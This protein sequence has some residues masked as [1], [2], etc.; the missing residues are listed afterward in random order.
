MNNIS[1]GFTSD[2]FPQGTH[3]C[4]IYKDEEERKEVIAK[5]VESGLLGGELVGYFVDAISPAEMRDHLSSLGISLS[6]GAK[7]EQL[8][9]SDAVKTYCCDGCFEPA[10]MLEKVGEFYR[11]SQTEGY[12]GARA[13]GEMAWALRGIPGS[14]KLI[15]YESRLNLLVEQN[16]ITLICQYDA[17]RFDGATIYDVLNVHPMMIVRGQVVRNPYYVPPAEFLASL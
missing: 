6:P 16:P 4:Y 9:I 11:R 13:T 8:A 17:N 1:L 10:A 15:E 14:E 2:L 3:I 5:F 12:N 7:Q